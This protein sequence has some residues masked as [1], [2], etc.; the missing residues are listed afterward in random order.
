MLDVR[1]WVSPLL[2]LREALWLELGLGLLRGGG[3]EL[4][5]WY[6]ILEEA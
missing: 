4:L 6:Q 5:D 2:D 1:E 3:R